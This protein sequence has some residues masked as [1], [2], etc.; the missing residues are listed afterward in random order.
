MEERTEEKGEWSGDGY[1]TGWERA[2][3]TAASPLLER[4]SMSEEYVR[5]IVDRWWRRG[6]ICLL[7]GI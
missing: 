1:S 7:P 6:L 5:C 3:Y 4:G 2:L